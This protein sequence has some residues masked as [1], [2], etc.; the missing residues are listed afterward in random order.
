MG[1][2][3][4]VLLFAGP[5]LILCLWWLVRFELIRDIQDNKGTK[6]LKNKKRNKSGNW[7]RRFLLLDYIKYAD[8]MMYSFFVFCIIFGIVFYF[9]LAVVTIWGGSELVSN[10]CMILLIVYLFLCYIGGSLYEIKRKF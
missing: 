2:I 4:G 9:A 6:I 8:R 5:F 10:V 1:S 7:I 3:I